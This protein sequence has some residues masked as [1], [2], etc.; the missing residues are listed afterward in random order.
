MAWHQDT[1]VYYRKPDD[2]RAIDNAWE[3]YNFFVTTLGWK[4]ESV[5]AMCGNMCQES[6][7]NPLVRAFNVSGAFGLTQLTTHK[8]DMRTWCLANGYDHNTGAGQCQYINYQKT[9]QSAADQWYQT[10]TYPISFTQ[11]A[12]NT[13]N[14]TIDELAKAFNFCYERP[15]PTYNTDRTRYA[16]YYY[17]LFQ[18]SPPGPGPGTQIWLY[19]HKKPW[20]RAGGRKYINA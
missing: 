12:D 16:N 1:G 15:G 8:Q 10:S 5:A 17:Q 18:G 2:T 11:F 6:T 4:V 20:Y 13:P 3:I 9:N 19:K 14:Y 7:M